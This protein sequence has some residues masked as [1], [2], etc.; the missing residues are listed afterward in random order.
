MIIQLPAGALRQAAA[1]P[2]RDRV[3][4]L[5]DPALKRE[6]RCTRERLQLFDPGGHDDRR[7]GRVEGVLAGRR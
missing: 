1:G 4:R 7:D 6:A 3:V 5:P 2:K